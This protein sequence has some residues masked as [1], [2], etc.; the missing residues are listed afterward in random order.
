MTNIVISNGLLTIG[1]KSYNASEYSANAEGTKIVIVHKSNDKNRLEEYL[2]SELKLNNAAYVTT[3]TFCAAFNALASSKEAL[4]L[5]GVKANT[6]YPDTL[7]S[8]KKTVN[9]VKVQAA[10]HAKPGYIEIETADDNSGTIY[11]GGAGVDANSC[12]MA[13][14]KRRSFEVDDL[15]KIWLLGSGAGQVVNISGAYKN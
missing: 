11:V 1:N 5:L 3:A 15:S 7:I 4:D 13:A 8:E 2:L 12:N 9:A 10:N 6:N 14:G